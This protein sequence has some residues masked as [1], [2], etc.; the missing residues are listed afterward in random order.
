MK[1]YSIKELVKKIKDKEISCV[2]VL[3]Y[4]VK[5]IETLVQKKENPSKIKMLLIELKNLSVRVAGSLIATGVVEGINLLEVP[6]NGQ[7]PPSDF[8]DYVIYLDAS[9]EDLE[10]WYLDRYHLMLEINRN[11]PDNYFYQWAHVPREQADIFA[12][13][14][15]RDV[16]LKNLHEYI[17]PTKKRA[18]MIIKKY[19]NHE[20]SDMY[21]KKF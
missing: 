11:N 19:G 4:Y 14:V 1:K 10:R 3:D 12:K 2:E 8:L 7:A 15:W 5:E 17:E 20:I 16:N 18:D 13:K 21:I 6:P 9:E